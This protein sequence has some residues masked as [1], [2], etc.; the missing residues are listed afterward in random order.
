MFGKKKLINDAPEMAKENG[1]L[2]IDV[3]SK[4]EYAEG[5]LPGAINKPVEQIQSW[6][7]NLEDKDQELY[8]YCY[9]GARSSA[10]CRALKKEGFSKVTNCGGIA[11]YFGRIEK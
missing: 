10:A 2:L 6:I 5:H 1:G 7:G 11:S 8:L 9:S 4:Q 3:R